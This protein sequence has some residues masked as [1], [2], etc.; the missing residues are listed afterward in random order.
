MRFLILG[1]NGQLGRELTVALSAL[2]EVLTA[3]RDGRAA[4]GQTALAADLAHPEQLVD[5]LRRA[6]PDVVANA[7]AYTAVDRAEEEPELARLVNAEAPGVLA[8]E[9]ARA[10]ALL[11]HYSTDYV[12]GGAPASVPAGRPARPWRETDPTAPVNVYGR[13]KRDGEEAV[14]AAGGPHLVF[15]TSW[16]Y[17]GHGHNFLRTM[18][19][20]GAERDELRIV[21]DQTGAPTWARPLALATAAVLARLGTAAPP[22]EAL[23]DHGGTYHLAAG[24][25]TTWHGFAVEI[26]RLAANHG[27]IPR[28]PTVIPITTAEFGAPAPRPPYS[29]LDCA[30]AEQTFGVRLP[31]WSRSLAACLADLAASS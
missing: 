29:V 4:P 19:R 14:R 20:L 30:R 6:R 21:D 16:V 26:F 18:L 8:A 24:G 9:A 5:V 23:A 22:A 17:A 15:R 3:T 28:A 7:A 11:V 13:T 2:G 25:E 1:A 31:E 12:F 27:L 10:G